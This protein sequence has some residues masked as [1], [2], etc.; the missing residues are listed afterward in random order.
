MKIKGRGR[1]E[2]GK[3]RSNN[4]DRFFCDPDRGIFVVADGVGGKP[5]GEVASETVVNSVRER[6]DEFHQLLADRSEELTSVEREEIFGH[7]QQAFREINS[8]VF[9]IGRRRQYPAGIATTADWMILGANSAF[10]LHVGDSRIYLLRDEEIFRLTRD[11]TFTEHLHDHPQLLEQYKEPEK[12]SNILT[13]SVGS[14]MHVEIDT[15][16]VELEE[17]DRFLMC[18]DGITDYFGG[19]EILNF[20]RGRDDEEFI[21]ELA[22]AANDSGGKDNLTAV[23]VRVAPAAESDFSRGATRYDTFQRVRCLQSLDLFADLEM[24]EILKVLRFVHARPCEDG[25]E[26][27]SRG[28]QVDGI[29]VVMEGNLSVQIEGRE[30]NQ[31]Q[32]GEHFGEFALFGDPVRSADVKALAPSYLLYISGESLRKLVREDPILGNKL[33]TRLLARMS[34]LIQELVLEQ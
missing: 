15:I 4:E 24:Q 33:L 23:T 5:G 9:R 29:Y 20:A 19:A 12:Y 18:T 27:V 28:D 25:E 7:L 34:R 11:H 32:T 16:F 2:V 14:S 22:R 3:V 17:G 30:I 13:R 6:A 1:S 31:I 8:E 21:H 10:I 26:V